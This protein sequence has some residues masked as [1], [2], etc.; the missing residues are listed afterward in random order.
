MP[1]DDSYTKVLLHFDGVDL[2]TAFTD[3]SGKTWTAAGNAKTCVG[4][5]KFGLASGCFDGLGNDY[6]TTPQHADF[7]LGSGDFTIDAWVFNF[8]FNSYNDICMYGT[9]ASRGYCFGL[10]NNTV[11]KFYY[12]TNGSTDKGVQVSFTFST[13]AWY[14]V[15][16]SVTGGKMYFFVNGTLINA[17]GTAFSDTIYNANTAFVIGRFGDYTDYNYAFK[18]F[19]DEFRLSKGIARWT[20]T[21]T[22]SNHAYLA[23]T[24]YLHA[25]RD[26]MNLR[27]VST[28]NILA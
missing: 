22:P 2:G 16:V 25:R 18:G 1:I 3:E 28:Q 20:N 11:L 9:L 21:F 6:I 4:A 10:V 26:R 5:K 12:T 24:T 8:Y 7:D 27:G 19:I 14:H 13:G 17:G 15:A 23:P